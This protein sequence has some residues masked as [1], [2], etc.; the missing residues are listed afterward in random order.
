MVILAFLPFGP[1]DIHELLRKRVQPGNIKSKS[2][3][4]FV[5]SVP[6]GEK[7]AFDWLT[8]EPTIS[9]YLIRWILVGST[10]APSRFRLFGDVRIQDDGVLNNLT[11]NIIKLNPHRP[12]QRKKREEKI[13]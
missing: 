3:S 4:L 5:G 6:N 10:A 7:Y 12:I 2:P 8:A 13:E 1:I 9:C 11:I